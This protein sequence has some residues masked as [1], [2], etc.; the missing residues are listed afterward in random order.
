MANILVNL[1][2]RR[3]Y[4]TPLI[5]YPEAYPVAIGK[6]ETP[7]PSG[8]YS[9]VN[10]IINPGGILGTR[11]MEISIPT[12]SGPYGIH[13]TNSPW[14]IGKA[15]SNGCIRMYN[16]DVEAIFS[17]C[18]IGTPVEII[19][20]NGY[21]A[22]PPAPYQWAKRHLVKP[23]DTFYLIAKRYGVSLQALLQVNPGADPL[24]LLPGQEI[25]I[26]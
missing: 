9:I 24:R 20:G 13:G 26:P 4:F 14:S 19:Q 7:T 2:Y 10:K 16:N 18:H 8:H 1:D 25:I 15:I 11:W 3:L 23:R 12:D 6:P 22:S 17:R 21:Y 5:G